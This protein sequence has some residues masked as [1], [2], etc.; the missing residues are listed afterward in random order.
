MNINK[1]VSS[2]SIP[3]PLLLGGGGQTD[4]WN[5]KRGGYWSVHRAF[6]LLPCSDAE[7]HQR[8]CL[9]FD[10]CLICL[11]YLLFPFPHKQLDRYVGNSRVEVSAWRTWTFQRKAWSKKSFLLLFTQEES[12]GGEK[13]VQLYPAMTE[14]YPSMLNVNWAASKQQS[15]ILQNILFLSLLT[16]L[17]PETATEDSGSSLQQI[18]SRVPRVTGLEYE[19]L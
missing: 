9:S 7:W 5:K 6:H 19:H 2:H 10:S 12:Q 8:D 18:K 1:Q 17:Y 13:R 11:W 16:S 4:T 14:K 3:V 15:L